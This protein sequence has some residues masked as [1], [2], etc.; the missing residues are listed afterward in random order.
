MLTR[1]RVAGD[2]RGL[3]FRHGVYQRMLQPGEYAK[4][5]KGYSLTNHKLSLPFTPE[6][7]LD[8]LLADDKLAADLELVVVEDG[9]IA[10]HFEDNRFM[11]FLK[12]GKHA[13]WKGLRKHRFTSLS[14]RDAEV[15]KQV[16]RTALMHSTAGAFLEEHEVLAHE[17]GLLSI[18]GEFIRTL[19]PGRYFFWKGE[20]KVRVEKVD[21]RQQQLEISGQEIMSQDQISLRMNFICHY[22]IND[23]ATALLKIQNY[24]NQIHVLMQL[25]LREYVGSLRLDEILQKKEEIGPF[26]LERM[27]ARGPELGIEFL[28]AGVRDIILP[29]EIRDIM[30]TVLAAEKKAQANII[31]RREETAS[32]RSLLNTTK[33]MEDNPILFRLK[34]LEYLER[35]C[36]KVGG[37]TVGGGG[38]LLEQLSTLIGGGANG[39][40]VKS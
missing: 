22:R 3:L 39:S 13:F 28:F 32:T 11:R 6:Y 37:V 26:V 31:T 8:L 12:S 24:L 25:V 4:F 14:I 30:N 7:D 17:E 33:L 40:A 10:L 20:K 21:L 23:T 16:E 34:E 29:G 15:P 9:Q 18:D 36:E 19:K 38:A 5:G 27:S 35:I 1:F 2:E